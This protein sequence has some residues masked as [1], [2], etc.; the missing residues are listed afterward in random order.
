MELKLEARAREETGKAAARRLRAGGEVPAVMY[1]LGSE[2]QPLVVEGSDIWEAIRGEAGI[3]VLIDL[4]VADGGKKDNH[5]VMIKELQRH[6][7]KD[8]IF[9]VDFLKIARDEV[10]QMKVPINLIGEEDALGIKAGGTLQHNLWDLEVECLPT[11]IPESL[12]LDI[13]ALEIGDNLRVSELNVPS[14]VTVLTDRDEVIATILAPRMEEEEEEE[15]LLP[16]ELEAE[17]GEGPPE[18]MEEG[19]PPEDGEEG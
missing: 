6:P 7:F 4:Q 5:L 17:E 11:D 19:A 3:N 2:P 1:G 15:E 13:S 16:E 10:V 9:H 14:A 18:E 12:E 8:K